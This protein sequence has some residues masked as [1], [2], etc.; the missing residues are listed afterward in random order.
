MFGELNLSR[1]CFLRSAAMTIA[2]SQFAT[3]TSAKSL[4]G[5]GG[6]LAS[7]GRATT[8]LNS[9][10]LSATQLAG[11]IVLVEFWTYSC[12]NWR[13]QLPFVRAWAEKY[14]DHGLVVIGVHSPEFSFEKEIDNIRWALND[15]RISYPVAVDND[16]AIWRGFNNEYWPALYFVDAKGKI[17]HNQ[18]GEGECGQSEKVIQKLLAETGVGGS[19]NE[20]VSVDPTGAEAVA[21]WSD[22]RSGEN[23]LGFER[24]E[25]FKSAGAAPDKQRIY[26]VPAKLELDQWALSGNWTIGKEAIVLNESGGSVVYRFHARDVHL[27]MGPAAPGVSVRFRVVVDGHPPGMAHGVDVDDQG[28]GTVKEP[29]M[30]QLVRQPAPIFDRQFEIQFLDAGVEGYSFTFG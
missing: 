27:V 1:R 30:Y 13:R 8:W 3:I 23:Y 19:R 12:I 6:E 28:N 24:T 22:L 5:G 16:H 18:F 29:R 14:K 21:D 25:N 26:S 9:Q 15:M 4:F 17:R 11:K 2:A 10:P 7:L 20:L